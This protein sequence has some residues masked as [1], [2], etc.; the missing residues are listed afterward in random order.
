MQ[1]EISY[2]HSIFPRFPY[3]GPSCI[4]LNSPPPPI[5]P[6]LAIYHLCYNVI[7]SVEEIHDACPI[8][9]LCSG[10]WHVITSLIDSCDIKLSLETYIYDALSPKNIAI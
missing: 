6:G 8:D 10:F 1:M 2:S 3:P 9:D 4:P 5:S 7:A